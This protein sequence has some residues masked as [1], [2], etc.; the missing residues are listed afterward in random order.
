MEMFHVLTV[1][2]VTPVQSC[3]H[4][5][6]KSTQNENRGKQEKMPPMVLNYKNSPFQVSSLPM[7]CYPTWVISK[8]VQPLWWVVLGTWIWWVRFSEC[9]GVPPCSALRPQCQP[10]PGVGTEVQRWVGIK[11]RGHGGDR[12]DSA[13]HA[14]SPSS[15]IICCPP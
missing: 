7:G 1:V 8:S 12:R 15:N 6:P 5:L 9:A 2:V 4:N 14:P 13:V 10:Y 3:L 11:V